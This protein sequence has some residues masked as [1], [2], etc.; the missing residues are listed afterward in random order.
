MRLL[1][2]GRL[3]RKSV[4]SKQSATP[5]ATVCQPW[6]LVVAHIVAVAEVPPVA[7]VE[8]EAC[9]HQRSVSVCIRVCITVWA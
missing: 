9:W 8:I 2:V 6:V 4:G 3:C 1:V 5:V 7:H